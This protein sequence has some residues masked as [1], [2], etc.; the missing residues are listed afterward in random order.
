MKRKKRGQKYK[1]I[2][3]LHL[4]ASDSLPESFASEFPP[5]G[6]LSWVDPSSCPDVGGGG[7]DLMCEQ[8]PFPLAFPESTAGGEGR[9]EDGRL[10]SLWLLVLFLTCWDVAVLL[11]ILLSMHALNWIRVSNNSLHGKCTYPH[12]V[13]K[14]PNE[15]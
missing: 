6:S 2:P 9:G 3:S 7:L 14:L 1:L 12:N 13:H 15:P 11:L 10:A 4:S 8:C 5:S